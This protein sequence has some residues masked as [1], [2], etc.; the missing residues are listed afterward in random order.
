MPSASVNGATLHYEERGEG[1]PVLFLHGTGANS[2]AAW[3]RCID[4]MPPGRRLISY[5][6]RGFGQSGARLASGLQDHVEDAAALLQHVG[7]AP[8]AIV[9]QSGGAVIALRLAIERPDLVNALVMAEPAYQVA[10]HPSLSVTRA[11]ARTLWKWFLRRDVEGAALHYYRWATSYET[12]GNAFD[13]YPESWKRAAIEHSRASLREVLQLVPPGPRA[14]AV[15]GITCPVTLVIGDDGEPVFRR[16]TS[17]V[18]RLLPTAKLAH[19]AETSHLIS[20]DQP[21]AFAAVVAEALGL[22]QAGAAG[23]RLDGEASSA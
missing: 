11:L 20:T 10:L 18:H 7:A 12:G 17:R 16:T 3:E 1:Q 4:A 2:P 19:V 14:R 21:R 22:D 6:R 9:T 15:R 5:D 8:A 13:G 23:E